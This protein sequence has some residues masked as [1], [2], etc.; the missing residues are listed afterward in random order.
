[1]KYIIDL[2]A[3][4]DCLDLLPTSY[5]DTG[6][7]DLCDVKKLIDRF[8]KDKA[9][10]NKLIINTRSV[11]KNCQDCSNYGW[12]MPQCRECDASN[13]F[14]YFERKYNDNE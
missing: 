4:K 14:K 12:D 3:L 1:M 9:D 5:S 13:S 2:D 8:P 11:F 10:E 6:F 7:V